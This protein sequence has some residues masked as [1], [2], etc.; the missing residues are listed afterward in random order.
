MLGSRTP[1]VGTPL[2]LPVEPAFELE[3]TELLNS[4][5]RTFHLR[6]TGSMQSLRGISSWEQLNEAITRGLAV[7]PAS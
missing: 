3:L 5:L 4:R 6:W 7:V 2:V 1:P